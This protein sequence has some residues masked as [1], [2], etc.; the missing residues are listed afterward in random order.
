MTQALNLNTNKKITLFLLI[1][2]LLSLIY[3]IFVP[4]TFAQTASSPSA[5]KTE[6]KEARMLKVCQVHERNIKNRLDSLIRLVTNQETKFD[7]IATRVETRYTEKLVPKGKTLSNY[8]DLV[9]DIAAKKAAVDSALNTAKSDVASFSC[10]APDPKSQLTTFRKDMQ[11]VKRAL[12]DFRK[13]VRN[14]IVAVRTL[15]GE[16]AESPKESPEANK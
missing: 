5:D 12:K 1:A 7:A 14:L 10:T 2:F 13:S 15:S 4:R 9:A 8:N 3:L 11:S 6:R 16:P